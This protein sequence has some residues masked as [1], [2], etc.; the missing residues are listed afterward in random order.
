MKVFISSF[1]IALL[2]SEASA[3]NKIRSLKGGKGDKN[4]GGAAEPDG[5]C[6]VEIRRPMSAPNVCAG[7][8]IMIEDFE[9]VVDGVLKAIGQSGTDVTVGYKGGND[10]AGRQPLTIPYWKQGIC[11]VNVHW[12]LGAEH[13]SE[14]QYDEDGSGP[15]V[16]DHRGL[17]EG[18]RLGLR[19]HHYNAEDEKFTK[20]YDWKHCVDMKVGET[21]E[22]H[23]PHS[24]AGACGTVNQYQTPFYDGVFCNADRLDLSILQEHVGVQAQVFTIV[25]DEEYYFPDLMRGMIVDDDLKMGVEITKYTGSTTGTNR[26]NEICSGYAP[27]TWQVDRTCHMVSASTFDKMCADMKM[28]RDGKNY[29]ICLYCLCVDAMHCFIYIPNKIFFLIILEIVDM[30]DDLYAHG[31][32][33]LVADHLASDNHVNRKLSNFVYY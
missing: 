28:Q 23:W 27:I 5:S 1:L 13:R 3:G 26:N 20:E 16:G 4:D 15:E 11:P 29:V 21:Y 8:K 33:E 24:L 30:S 32:R 18:A 25:N 19:C 22:V 31:A 14:G 9:C 7:S 6:P 2:A 10:T 12:H 17:A